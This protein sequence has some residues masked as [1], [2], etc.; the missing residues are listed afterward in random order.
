MSSNATRKLSTKMG[1]RFCT[2]HFREIRSGTWKCAD[3]DLSYT[4]SMTVWNLKGHIY[5]LAKEAIEDNDSSNAF[6][7]LR[8]IKD[9]IKREIE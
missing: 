9:L 4:P 3:C 1:N 5:Q 7:T 8:E 2:H 6:D